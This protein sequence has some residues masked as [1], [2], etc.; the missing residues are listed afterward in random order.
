MMKR[1]ALVSIVI[2]FEARILFADE[3][4]FHLTCDETVDALEQKN[5]ELVEGKFGKAMRFGK[6]SVI[7]FAS[8][9]NLDRRKGTVCMWVKP[10]WE[11]EEKTSHAFF[12]DDREFKSGN[13][14]LTLAQRQ[15]L[16]K[17]RMAPRR[18]CMGLRCR[19]LAFC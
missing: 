14:S 9:G 8:K 2:I 16:E 17:R 18:R 19:Q 13:N 5:I 10:N 1:I 7:R 3:L 11:A 6:D 4:L 15:R 12:V